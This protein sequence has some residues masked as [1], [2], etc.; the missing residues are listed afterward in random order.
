MIERRK[1]LFG[2]EKSRRFAGFLSGK[3]IEQRKLAQIKSE[4]SLILRAS[5]KFSG[6]YAL[7]F[8]K[9]IQG[10]I[11]LPAGLSRRGI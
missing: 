11:N 8:A 10:V 7:C 2:A 4:I 1:P 5:K 6:I 9:V 3:F